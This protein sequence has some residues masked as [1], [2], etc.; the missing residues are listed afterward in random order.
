MPSRARRWIGSEGLCGIQRNACEISITC[1]FGPGGLIS[2]DDGIWLIWLFK[3]PSH[4]PQGEVCGLCSSVTQKANI[5]AIQLNETLSYSPGARRFSCQ[6]QAIAKKNASKRADNQKQA[7]DKTI[8]DAIYYA[9]RIGEALWG[10]GYQIEKPENIAER[11]IKSLLT[12]VWESNN[13]A[14][15]LTV[16]VTQLRKMLRWMNKPYLLKDVSKYLPDVD[17]NMLKRQTVATKSK[18]PEGNGIDPSEL[19]EKADRIDRRFGA[20]VQLQHNFGL[21]R[22]EVLHLKPH[23]DDKGL[24]LNLRPGTAKGGRSRTIQIVNEGQRA[25]LDLAKSL[26]ALGEH[27]GWPEAGKRPEGRTLLDVNLDRYKYFAKKL[28]LT[29]KDLG[30]TGH[31]LR[32]A[33]AENRAMELGLVPPT[34][35]GAK[36]QLPKAEEQLVKSTVAEEMGHGRSAVTTAY[37]GSQ[38]SVARDVASDLASSGGSE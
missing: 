33:F 11:H 2:G 9:K 12:W 26:V 15:T 1:G 3:D 14:G 32:A 23:L 22:K 31:G 29:R 5:M 17:P 10:L 19:Y 28:G 21:R 20:M 35:G 25:A 24:Y 18:S 38:R 30:I 7:S 4:K 27:L 37:Y 6:L 16:W 36:G 34:R 13:S 8:E